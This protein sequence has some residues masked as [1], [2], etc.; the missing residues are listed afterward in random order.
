MTAVVPDDL[1]PA[2]SPPAS[3][4]PASSPPGS[5]PPAAQ[6]VG[7]PPTG[8]EPVPPQPRA[9]AAPAPRAPAVPPRPAARHRMPAQRH[10]TRP[11]APG[12]ARAG[13]WLHRLVPVLT[14]LLA[15]ASAALLVLGVFVAGVVLAPGSAPPSLQPRTAE[16][17]DAGGA[18]LGALTGPEQPEQL[19]AS[20]LPPL[21]ASA[22][23]ADQDPGFASRS[24][25][26]PGELVLSGGADLLGVRRQGRTIETRYAHQ[27][28]AAAGASAPSLRE[29]AVAERLRQGLPRRELLVRYLNGQYFGNGVYGVAAASRYYLGRPLEDITPAGAALLVG[30]ADDPVRGNPVAD[31]ARAASLRGAALERMA[32]HH[33]LS[34]DAADSADREPVPQPARTVARSTG[35]AG[36]AFTAQVA[37]ELLGQLGE[38]TVYSS[39][40]RVTTTLDAGLQRL[41]GDR[42]TS[43]GAGAAGTIALAVDPRTGDVRALL[44]ATDAAAAPAGAAPVSAAA[45]EALDA[46]HPLGALTRA[47]NDKLAAAADRATTNRVALAGL[48]SAGSGSASIREVAAGYASLAAHG[49]ARP[50][51]FV[52]DVRTTPADGGR[53]RLV[54]A[55]DPYPG[56]SRAIDTGTADRVEG[57]LRPPS[58]SALPGAPSLAGAARPAVGAATVPGF[59]GGAWSVGCVPS[60]CVT[61]WRPGV[62]G[63][64]LDLT[65]AVV[66]PAIVSWLAG[67]PLVEVAEQPAPGGLTDPAQTARTAPTAP[68]PGPP[69]GQYVAPQQWAPPIPPVVRPAPAPVG[70][71]PT[72]AA[73][74]AAPAP[75]SAPA[76]A[77]PVPPVGP[78]PPSLP[79]SPQPV[80]SASPTAPPSKAAQRVPV[81]H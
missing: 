49:A 24:T 4:P 6:A 22:V 10:S 48:D 9:A 39:G 21:L 32:A 80:S 40:L 63:A 53:E 14:V 28:R 74:T 61:V 56:G 13:Q 66:Q 77:A 38:A 41:I 37:S 45:A 31:P 69:V 26:S 2:S 54:S 17:F 20:Q 51:R 25:V 33:V 5:S 23:V 55:A 16:L 62:L 15:L 57:M 30:I 68:A 73:P 36:A 52:A 18:P 12:W 76:S 75:P 50:L 3:S 1:H 70:A 11:A 81:E 19:S 58:G 43:T 64:G 59:G 71:P 67:H 65:S 44:T 29:S 78:A 46:D 60:L 8:L 35:I 34:R 7:A 47:A 79:P 72:G 27:L 42:L